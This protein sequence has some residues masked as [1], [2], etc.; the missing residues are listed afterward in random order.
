MA[1]IKRLPLLRRA[2]IGETV[3]ASAFGV[4]PIYFSLVLVCSWAMG[5]VISPASATII[6]IAALTA[7]SPIRVGIF[8]NGQYVLICSAAM[9]SALTLLRLLGLI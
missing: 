5:V 1:K 4:T 3:S 2:I 7:Q 9:I 6:A 8:W